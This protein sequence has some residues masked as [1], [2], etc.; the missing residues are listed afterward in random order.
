MLLIRT[1]I[2]RFWSKPYKGRLVRWGTELHD[3][4]SFITNVR[5]DIQEVVSETFQEADLSVEKWRGL[6]RS[7]KPFLEIGNS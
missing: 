5:A 6:T 2:A 4:F 7:L 1:L 3:R